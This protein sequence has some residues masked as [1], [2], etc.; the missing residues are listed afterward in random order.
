MG[1]SKEFVDICNEFVIAKQTD[2]AWSNRVGELTVEDAKRFESRG[3][4]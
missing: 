4:K 2:R 3:Q 1:E